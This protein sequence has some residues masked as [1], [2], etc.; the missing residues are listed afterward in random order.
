MGITVWELNSS[1]ETLKADGKSL[2]QV[3]IEMQRQLLGKYQILQGEKQNCFASLLNGEGWCIT[4]FIS[5]SIDGV[6]PLTQ[7]SLRAEGSGAGKL[8]SKK[9]SWGGLGNATLWALR[10]FVLEVDWLFWVSS[11]S[12]KCCYLKKLNMSQALYNTQEFNV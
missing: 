9:Y 8:I 11:N 4:L 6:N 12:V 3:T 1:L 2:T 5:C 7:A 10:P